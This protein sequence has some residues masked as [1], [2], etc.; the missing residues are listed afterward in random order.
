MANNGFTSSFTVDPT[1][2]PSSNVHAIRIPLSADP[3]Q[4]YLVEVRSFTGFDKALPATG[5]LITSVDENAIIGKV[6]VMDG[7][8]GVSDLEDAVWNIG[9]TFSDN[10]NNIA[11]TVT[12]KVGNSYQVTV[13]RGG[14]PPPPNQNQSYV[15]LAITGVSAQPPVITFPNTTVTITIQVSNL[16]TSGVTNV[17]VGVDLDGQHY[18]NTRGQRLRGFF[19][20]N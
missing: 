4:Y 2:V 17:P 18:T 6:H 12:G 15:D 13:N 5:V 16:G 19:N 8:P 10:Q 20:R 7:H 1:E 3:S 14:A 11:V 9:Q